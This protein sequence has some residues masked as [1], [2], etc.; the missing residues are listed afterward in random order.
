[1]WVGII[2]I[3]V[4]DLEF[5]IYMLGTARELVAAGTNRLGIKPYHLPKGN[6]PIYLNPA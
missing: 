5:G 4:E 6:I 1:V 3:V 2:I